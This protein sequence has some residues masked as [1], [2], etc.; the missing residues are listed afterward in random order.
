MAN[1]AQARKRARQAEERRA[2]NQQ[3]RS[4]VR[5]AIKKVEKATAGGDAAAARAAL[6]AA[7]PEIDTMAGKRILKKNAA[8]RYKHRLNLAI[9]RLST[10]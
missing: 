8:S 4:R 6:Q 3:L 10:P 2:R 1:T 7:T 9:R 5:S